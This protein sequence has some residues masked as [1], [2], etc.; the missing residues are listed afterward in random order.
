M[1]KTVIALPQSA[2]AWDA[3][4]GDGDI[5]GLKPAGKLRE[6]LPFLEARGVVDTLDVG[7][8]LGRNT[9]FLAQSGFH[10]T[11]VDCSAKAID[12]LR[13]RTANCAVDLHIGSF[14]SLPL[15]DDSFDFALANHTLE[16]GTRADLERGV[17]ELRRVTR[18]TGCILVSLLADDSP[19]SGKG[20]LDVEGFSHAAEMIRKQYPVQFIGESEVGR[21]FSDF[22][23]LQKEHRISQPSQGKVTVPLHEWVI[24]AEADNNSLHR[25]S[26]PQGR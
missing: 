13:T 24:L 19:L 18:P 4:Y 26:L 20:Q 15:P 3:L 16:Y 10:V 17:A 11:G 23:I 2:G 7:C 14:T 25:A 1:R 5:H 21:L 22:N 8:A 12:I 9:L 6:I